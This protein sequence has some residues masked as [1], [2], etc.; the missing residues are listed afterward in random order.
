M[1]TSEIAEFVGGELHGDSDVEITSVASIADAKSGQIAFYEKHSDMP[2]IDASCVI[3]PSRFAASEAE[4]RPVGSV[5]FSRS[6]PN[7]SI[8]ISI[9]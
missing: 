9:T 3:V 4:T 5:C 2:P 7:L 1:K 8:F 6:N